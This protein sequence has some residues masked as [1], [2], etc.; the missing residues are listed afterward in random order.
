MK[1]KL[2]ALLLLIIFTQTS[3]GCDEFGQ[4]GFMP[5][6]D[7]KIS[8]NDKFKSDMTEKEFNAIIDKIEKVYK[9]VVK[10]EHRRRLKVKRL[11]SNN[12]VNASANRIFFTWIVNMYG[13]LAR[14]PAVTNDGFAMVVCHELGHHLGG[15]PRYS[16]RWASNEGQADYFGATKCFK[17]VYEKDDNER[18]I[19]AMEVDEVAETKCQEAYSDR[20]EIAL[21]IRTAMA[22]KS[23]AKLLGRGSNVDLGS[24]DPNVVT[25]TNNKHPAG[26][27]RLDTYFQGGLCTKSWRDEVDGRNPN[28]GVCTRAEGFELG[29]RPL[30]WYKPQS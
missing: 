16:G 26:Q 18:I 27:C 17:R 30:C 5:E 15:A 28:K 29:L 1:A 14:H 13:G 21:C 20:K 25:Q 10:K 23:L 2:A 22:G 9:P 7:M 11:W 4:T 24:P 19:A 8:V 12:T 3:F 6:N